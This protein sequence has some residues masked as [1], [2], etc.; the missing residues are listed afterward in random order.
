[1]EILGLT[2]KKR[3]KTALMVK[4][5]EATIQLISDLRQDLERKL[6]G[7]LGGRPSRQE[8]Q[9]IKIAQTHL[10]QMERLLQG[11]RPAQQRQD[12]ASPAQQ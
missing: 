11:G 10:T 8:L 5:H 12:Q 4:G 3:T 6:Q 9:D 1:M 2:D 7:E